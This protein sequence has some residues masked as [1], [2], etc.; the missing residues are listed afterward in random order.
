VALRRGRH[1]VDV[2]YDASRE[3][4]VWNGRLDY[5]VTIEVR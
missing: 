1:R 3:T 4:T 2:V 5:A